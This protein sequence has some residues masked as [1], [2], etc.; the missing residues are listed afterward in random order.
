MD[1]H[2]TETKNVK[3]TMTAI[4]YTKREPVT[5]AITTSTKTATRRETVIIT[6][7]T[8]LISTY[9]I[10]VSCDGW[11]SCCES[12]HEELLNIFDDQKSSF[13]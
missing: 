13:Q 8:T 2:L 12:S 5:I 3:I 9:S 7:T 11:N 6:K 10:V 1:F 4:K